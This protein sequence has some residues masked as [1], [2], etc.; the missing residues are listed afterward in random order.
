MRFLFFISALLC[1]IKCQAQ[2]ILTLSEVHAHK[3]LSEKEIVQLKICNESDTIFYI[4]KQ[5]ERCKPF[6]SFDT[7][8]VNGVSRRR[9]CIL[10][11]GL[12][13]KYFAR[14]AFIDGSDQRDNLNK[15][16]AYENRILR[17]N[18][19][20]ESQ[21]TDSNVLF[22]VPAHSVVSI[23]AIVAIDDN[24]MYHFKGTSENEQERLSFT[25]LLPLYFN[26]RNSSSKL[27]RVLESDSSMALKNA[28]IKRISEH[29]L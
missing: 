13:E 20:I 22:V 7:A 23:N 29:N 1:G 6:A 18:R 26:G 10:V 25:L 28:I 12:D 9:P 8:M 19:Q 5:I 27:V 14:A 11:S 2:L 21:Q 15:I 16:N 3:F 24:F 4:N 17:S